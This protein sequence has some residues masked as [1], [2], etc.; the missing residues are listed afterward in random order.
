MIQIVPELAR[1]I[2]PARVFDKFVYS[3]WMATNLGEQLKA[4]AVDTLVVTGAETDMCVLSTVL[5]AI[6]WGFR[7]ILVADA[8]CSSS[9]QTHDSTM[10]I[11]GNRFSEQVEA[12]S[13]EQLLDVWS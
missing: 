13:T 1:F 5:G 11:Y 7:V 12:V 9:D 10:S 2:P 3:P 6:D 8:L 4:A